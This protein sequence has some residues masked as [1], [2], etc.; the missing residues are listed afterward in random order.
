MQVSAA[1]PAGAS[2][3]PGGTVTE[4]GVRSNVSVAIQYIESWLRG[5]GAAAINNLME[6]A[7]TAEISRSQIWQWL[8]QGVTLE[9]RSEPADPRPRPALVQ[10]ELGK[11]RQALGEET[12]ARGRF[13]EA[14]RLFQQVSLSDGLRRVPHP[15]RLRQSWSAEP[16]TRPW[17]TPPPG[18]RHRPRRSVLS[19]PASNPRFVARA[20]QTEADAVLFDLEDSVA[21]ARKADTRALIV[22]ALNETDFGGKLRLVRIN[23]LSTP[24]AVRDVVDLVEGAGANLDALMLPKTGGPGDVYALDVMLGSLEAQ[25]GLGRRIGIEA[26]IESAAR[27]GQRGG[28][29]PR[30]PAPGDARLRAGR[31]RRLGGHAGALDRRGRRRPGRSAP[32]DGVAYPG[33][34]WHYAIQRIVVAAKAAGLQAINGPYGRFRDLQGLRRAAALDYV[35]GMDGKWA[36]HPSQIPVLNEVF[37]PAPEQVA[38]AEAILARYRQ[39]VEE[40]GVGAVAFGEEMIDEASRRLAESLLRRPGAERR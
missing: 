8:E 15:P 3:V 16:W 26:Q 19:V 33:H 20:A 24:W 31:L 39:A 7:A 11:I 12:Y 14:T 32:P 36:V 13:E 38:Q 37:T 35:L 4:A 40:E 5:V 9:R 28:H 6:D 2:R 30:Q 25:V 34:L 27:D 18:S 17:A 21:P 1:G 22:R 29:R 23:A 10:E